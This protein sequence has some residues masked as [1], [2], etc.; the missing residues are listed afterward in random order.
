MPAST[1]HNK[2]VACCGLHCGGCRKYQNGRC[3]GCHANSEA[4][5]CQ[6]RRCCAERHYS[7]CADCREY[8]NPSDCAKFNNTLS[9]LFGLLF[10]SDRAACI[11]AI[12]TMGLNE[13][14]DSMAAQGRHTLPRWG[15]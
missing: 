3:P 7:S 15:R 4:N 1:S 6:V 11:A 2:L 12:K 8:P 14:A 5:W 10:N 13:Y 9:K